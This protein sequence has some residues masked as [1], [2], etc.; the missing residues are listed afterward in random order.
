VFSADNVTRLVSWAAL[1]CQKQ[2]SGE[3]S[4][5]WMLE[6]W[7][8]AYRHYDEP[9]TTEF[10]QR[11]GGLVEPRKNTHGEWRDVDVRVGFTVMPKWDKVPRLMDALVEAWG[12]LDSDTWYREF[13]EVHPFADGNGR[14]G[15]ILWNLHRGR[16]N[17][18]QVRFPPDFWGA[19]R[20]RIPDNRKLI[21][22]EDAG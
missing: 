4:V 12:E 19:G 6:G 14:T 5:W 21:S 10:V 3:A 8:Y 13:E 22:R 20:L 11:V 7:S 17:P 18:W 16:L 15:N 1:E 9:V 2:Q